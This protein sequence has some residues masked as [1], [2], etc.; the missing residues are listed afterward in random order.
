ME[1]LE[2]PPLSSS[3]ALASLAPLVWEGTPRAHPAR[4]VLTAAL[5]Q[6]AAR[7][8]PRPVPQA[9][10]RRRLLRAH[11][12]PQVFFAPFQGRSPPQSAH[13]ALQGRGA[14]LGQPR[15]LRPARCARRAPTAPRLMQPALAPAWPAL[16]V[17]Y[18]RVLALQPSPRALAA[19]RGCSAQPPQL[20]P[21]SPCAAGVLPR[22]T[23]FP[24][25][26]TAWL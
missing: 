6:A 25:N 9:P 15:L 20:F 2:S 3:T 8:P 26:T 19:L 24:F 10:M 12:V 16:W 23:F 22:P 18:L 13:R 4:P 5:A 17:H 7:L 11:P 1:I 21:R 14:F